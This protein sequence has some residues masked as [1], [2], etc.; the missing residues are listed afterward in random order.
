MFDEIQSYICLSYY[1]RK[2]GQGITTCGMIDITSILPDKT[3][4]ML[5]C[6]ALFEMKAWIQGS[7]NSLM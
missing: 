2:I 1:K 4:L 3:S 7:H 5:T 6:V